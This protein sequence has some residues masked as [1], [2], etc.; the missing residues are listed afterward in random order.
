MKYKV[1]TNIVVLLH[2]FIKCDI[3]KS[4]EMI[5]YKVAHS[6]GRIS[7]NELSAEEISKLAEDK[8]NIQLTL[9]ILNRF[10]ERGMRFGDV[11]NVLLHGKIIE[12]YPTDYPFP[13]CLELGST[14]NGIPLHVCC[15][16]GENKIWIITAY[17][18]S[19]DKW[20]S[21]LSTRKVVE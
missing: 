10:K 19:E 3:I 9:H 4:L 12:Q 17:Y 20:E 18:P 16:V 5:S 13:S 15:G 11:Q 21:D 8:K 14:I 6:I 1:G 7:M 2:I